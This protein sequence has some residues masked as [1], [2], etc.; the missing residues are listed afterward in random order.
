MAWTVTHEDLF[1]K[2]NQEMDA[3]AQSMWRRHGNEVYDRANEIAAM[4]LCYN[5]LVGNLSSYS[6][7][8][9]EPLLRE[10]KPLEAVCR[11]W[12]SELK[13]APGESF[14]RAIRSYGSPEES[15]M[16]IGMSG[17]TMGS[18]KE[19]DALC[20]VSYSS[21]PTSRA[22]RSAPPPI[23]KTMS[24]TRPPERAPSA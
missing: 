9:L 13:Y 22:A 10:E 23:C 7:E 4:H 20:P 24:A 19:G 16:S 17:P 11:S 12:M 3:Y 2:I 5:Q 1:K 18:K 14:D 6:S 8:E 15:K 21:A